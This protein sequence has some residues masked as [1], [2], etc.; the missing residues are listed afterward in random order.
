MATDPYGATY[1][2]SVRTLDPITNDG[3]TDALELAFTH[4]YKPSTDFSSYSEFIAVVEDIRKGPPHETSGAAYIADNSGTATKETYTVFASVI[5]PKFDLLPPTTQYGDGRSRDNHIT[6]MK[7]SLK[8]N[9][10]PSPDA[11][12]P[13]QM[14]EKIRVTWRK[15]TGMPLFDWDYPIYLGPVNDADP[16]IQSPAKERNI[17]QAAHHK[18][19]STDGLPSQTLAPGYNSML[20][21]PGQEKKNFN[22][23]PPPVTANKENYWGN[24][25]VYSPKKS[26]PTPEKNYDKKEIHVEK[27]L[28]YRDL[29]NITMIPYSDLL[30][31]EENIHQR[32][33]T[34]M[35]IIN[36]TGDYHSAIYKKTTKKPLMHYGIAMN[37]ND[38]TENPPKECTIRVNIPYGLAI[39]TPDVFSEN[40]IGCMISSPFDGSG[41]NF[42]NLT[43]YF[44]GPITSKIISTIQ[45]GISQWVNDKTIPGGFEAFIMG[46]F[47]TPGLRTGP[48]KNSNSFHQGKLVWTRTGHYVLPNMFQA[49][50]LY[51]LINS[52]VNDPPLSNYSWGFAKPRKNNHQLS[53]SFPAVGGGGPIFPY[54]NFISKK[55]LHFLETELGF[56]WARVGEGK[57]R[58]RTKFRQYWK[59]QLAPNKNISGIISNSRW[60]RFTGG[61]FLEY[62][63]LSRSLNAGHREAWYIALGA[64]SETYP[65]QYGGVGFGPSPLPMAADKNRLVQK[66]QQ[67]WAQATSYIRKG[68]TNKNLLYINTAG[69]DKSTVSIQKKS[70]QKKEAKE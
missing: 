9:F 13:P 28:D 55:P 17:A 37:S 36:E 64:A 1:P 43:N 31:E 65:K 66:G 51:E 23:E 38:A 56:P 6:N 2:Q 8:M 7:E 46:P 19:K 61:A 22:E 25:H 10:L 35:I 15:K 52:L 54:S 42:L 4:Y 3:T 27:K 41:R 62:Y 58:K 60:D 5:A 20:G 39:G 68:V 53:W 48:D 70:Y 40:C 44:Q 57:Y 24:E 30:P 33:N 14:G 67:M 49:Y 21:S 63:L 47:G 26:A 32:A 18:T 59:N 69:K 12:R 34:K 16:D 45:E 50:A 11:P 29:E